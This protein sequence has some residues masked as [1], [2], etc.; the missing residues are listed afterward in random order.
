MVLSGREFFL[1]PVD[2]PAGRGEDDLSDTITHA[3]FE[4]PQGAKHVHV[5]VEVR[6]THG[7]PHVHLRSLM[8]ERLGLKLFE[9]L[10]AAGSDVGLVEPGAVG[11]VLAPAGREVVDYCDLVAPGVT[12]VPRRA[13]L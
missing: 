3:I 10:G 9:D 7:A 4:E 12:G 5:G 13:S 11:D 1:L 2:R 6:L 8:G